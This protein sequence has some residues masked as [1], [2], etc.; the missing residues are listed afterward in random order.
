V[1]CGGPGVHKMKNGKFYCSSSPNA[2]PGKQKKIAEACLK[3]FGVNNPTKSPTVQERRKAH[4]IEKY[5]VDHPFKLAE[6][7]N[8]VAATNLE[9]YG[10]ENPF[11]SAEIQQKLKAT[12]LERFGVE[13]VS[14]S[15]IVQARR[16]ATF[17][18]R[19]GSPQF[20]GTDLAK[21][22]LKAWSQEK[23]GTDHPMQNPSFFRMQSRKRFRR[24]LV[25]IEGK[26]FSVQGFE[27][28]VL[29]ELVHSGVPVENIETD[30][31]KVPE[32]WYIKENGKRA[33]YYPDIFISSRNWLIE[34]KSMYTFL[35]DKDEN[36]RK[37]LACLEKGYQFN[38]VI[39]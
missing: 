12:N 31:K 30:P 34:V 3:K 20:L 38:F 28:K 16:E 13:N 2:C 37:R 1:G 32:I 23:Y 27:E 26:D 35:V 4:N 7:Q 18:K 10:S 17:L 11:G 22:G 36:L 33:R 9:R 5:G 15:P 19:F 8:R 14:Q 29:K 24:K 6:L 39:R 25:T 21:D